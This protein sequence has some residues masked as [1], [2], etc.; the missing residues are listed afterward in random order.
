MCHRNFFDVR[1]LI[2]YLIVFRLTLFL[3]TQQTLV[4]GV[5][6]EHSFNYNTV[7]YAR[8][9]YLPMTVYNNNNN[10][11]NIIK[12]STTLLSV[13]AAVCNNNIV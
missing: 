13:S 1:Y 9:R 5:I 11:N 12:Q 10:K 6:V 2:D 4:R 3:L 7:C 8:Y